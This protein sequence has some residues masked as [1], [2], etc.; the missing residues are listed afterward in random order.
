[1]VVD[2][3]TMLHSSYMTMIKLYV[4]FQMLSFSIS[5]VIALKQNVK[6]NVC[7]VVILL[8]AKYY[9]NKSSIF[10]T[11]ILFKDPKLPGSAT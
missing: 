4:K 8:S 2:L 6:E 1:M 3:Q 11:C 5:F 10:R 9:H 7:F